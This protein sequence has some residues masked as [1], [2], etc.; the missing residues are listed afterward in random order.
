MRKWVT[1]LLTVLMI[2]SLAGCGDNQTNQSSEDNTKQAEESQTDA[3][4]AKKKVVTSFYPIYVLALN[5]T[6]GVDGVEVVNLTQPQTGCLHDYQLTT[7]DMKTLADASVLLING[8]GMESFLEKAMNQQPNLTIEDTSKGVALVEGSDDEEEYNPHIW[9]SI[10]NAVKQTENIRDALIRLDPDN[11]E[12]YRKN[13][14]A[15]AESMKELTKKMRPFDLAERKK[16]GIFHEGFD[17]FAEDFGFDAEIDIFADENQ[18]PSAKELAEAVEDAKED[19]I[20]LFFAADDQ[21]KEIAQAIVNEV[22]GQ[23]ILLDP[24][25]RGEMN[26]DAYKNA[27]EKNISALEEALEK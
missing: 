4:S 15:F 18:E 22:G 16:A 14:E 25:T 27:M 9:L 17:Y 20:Q 6:D 21:G 10:P 23:V 3:A 1:C 19:Q 2:F 12:A 24:V 5:V 26:K 13:T 11:E 7:D 8:V